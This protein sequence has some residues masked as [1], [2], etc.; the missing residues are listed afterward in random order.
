MKF[1]LIAL[2]VILVAAIGFLAWKYSSDPVAVASHTTS[3]P[4]TS[5][6]VERKKSNAAL[7]AA[8]KKAAQDSP[9]AT[10][11][12]ITAMVFINKFK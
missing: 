8:Q 2:N 10:E 6:K 12:K 9:S 4:R 7:I 3:V 5:T 1:M 11:E